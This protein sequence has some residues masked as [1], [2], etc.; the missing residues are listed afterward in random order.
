MCGSKTV[1]NKISTILQD[2]IAGT[3]TKIEKK[4]EN[5]MFGINRKMGSRPG[6]QFG[7]GEGTCNSVTTK[8]TSNPLR[9]VSYLSV[10]MV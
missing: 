4:R 8:Y 3:C 10:W 1:E 9:N 2:N 5:I 7:K 6:T